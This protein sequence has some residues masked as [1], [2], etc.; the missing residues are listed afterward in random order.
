MLLV[1]PRYPGRDASADVHLLC[2]F[3][4][5]GEH[6]GTLR[7]HTDQ[8]TDGIGVYWSV[9]VHDGFVERSPRLFGLGRHARRSRRWAG[10]RPQADTLDDGTRVWYGAHLR[11]L[12]PNG[13]RSCV[14]ASDFSDGRLAALLVNPALWPGDTHAEPI[15]FAC[16]AQGHHAMLSFDFIEREWA[17]RTRT[18]VG[19]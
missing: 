17:K 7:R 5:C 11:V 16:A 13:E 4:C 18:R 10:R 8:A 6:V 1:R 19:N 3:P 2:G 14:P 9:R 15:T 12:L